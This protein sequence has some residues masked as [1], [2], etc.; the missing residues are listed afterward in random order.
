MRNYEKVYPRETIASL[1]ED[2]ASRHSG[3]PAIRREH[4]TIDL[5]E[6]KLE[7]RRAELDV[8]AHDE[9]TERLRTDA[10]RGYLRHMD[11]GAMG[12]RKRR[13]RQLELAVDQAKIAVG[14]AE[15]E[16]DRHDDDMA[17]ADQK[18]E[19]INASQGN[20]SAPAYA[21]VHDTPLTP[22]GKK[23]LFAAGVELDRAQPELPAD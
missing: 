15:I 9:E 12:W 18:A 23:A 20:A 14:H 2:Y 5:E 6:A 21:N 13:R 7:Q 11:A 8:A 16:I 1:K 19:A 10:D 22:T 17:M 4:L 3:S